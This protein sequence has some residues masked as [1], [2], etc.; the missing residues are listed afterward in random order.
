MAEWLNIL[1]RWSHLIFGIAWIGSSFYFM[2]LDS[3]LE[4]PPPSKKDV[5]GE[6]WM[7]HSG[8]FYLVERK[9][10]EPG[11]MPATLH[12]FKYEALFTLVTGFLLLNLVY[13][14]TGGAFLLDPSVSSIT[15]GQGVALGLGVLVVS[16]IVYDFIWQSK[17][18]LEKNAVALALSIALAAATA[19]L[20]CQY[21]SGRAAFI[22]LGAMFGTIMVT[23]VWMRILPAQQ[24]MID[25]TKEGRKPD[26]TLSAKAKRRSVHN[27][28]MTFPVLFMMI[29][30]H[31]ATV[32]SGPNNWIHL[33]LL[34]VFGM[35]V[36]HVTLAKKRPAQVVAGVVA[37]VSLVVLVVMTS[38]H[39][40]ATVAD[41]QSAVTFADVRP[42][43]E[44]R[45]LPCH[46]PTPSITEFGTVP[47]GTFFDTP[48]RTASFAERIR[49]RVVETKTMPPANKT[50]VTDEERELLG[51]WIAGGAK[52]GE[53][54]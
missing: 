13:Y 8:G 5:E 11:S 28:Y 2:W 20:L 49:L 7:V 34:I 46:S 45:C 31:Y 25:A 10:I 39:S 16:W 17:L 44:N 30:N 50:G 42:I 35:A 52:T 33:L 48:E 26:Y 4:A 24:K 40:Q 47:A 37:L 54:R 27:S 32:T 41:G 53:G 43:F 23:N 18:A 19:Y 36:R 3:N 29:S 1:L 22:H 15:H 51:R 14:F 6:L 9:L 12:W 21:L 38:S